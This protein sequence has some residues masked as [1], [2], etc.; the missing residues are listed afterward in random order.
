VTTVTSSN[1]AEPDADDA[2]FEGLLRELATR[3]AAAARNGNPLGTL[4][5]DKLREHYYQSR[6]PKP[7]ADKAEVSASDGVEPV[8]YVRIHK[9]GGNAGLAWHAEPT[10]ICVKDGEPLYTQS[11]ISGAGK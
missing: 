2:R 4:I 5:F 11:A 8:A 1:N 9:T 3:A 6:H 7:D 10:G